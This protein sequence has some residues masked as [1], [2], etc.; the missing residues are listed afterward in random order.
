MASCGVGQRIAETTLF[1]TSPKKSH[2][3]YMG[4]RGTFGYVSLRKTDSGFYIFRR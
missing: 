4:L 1:A 2:F 3:F